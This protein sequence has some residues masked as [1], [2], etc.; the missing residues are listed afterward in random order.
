MLH[1][2]ATRR[3]LL[4]HAGTGHFTSLVTV[5]GVTTRIPLFTIDPDS[6]E[7]APLPLRYFT[8][9]GGNW[10]GF[11]TAWATEPDGLA[12][13]EPFV[14]TVTTELI[15]EQQAHFL[16]LEQYE[17][18]RMELPPLASRLA[19]VYLD[20]LQRRSREAMSPDEQ[21]WN[22]LSELHQVPTDSSR[23]AQIYFLS[24]LFGVYFLC[25]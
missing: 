3:P 6:A 18:T 7:V 15:L 4:L 21:W 5:E 19:E 10:R 17:D 8:R 16:T 13:L 9:G 1:S 24:F 22:G 2:Y 23:P 12:V 25:D 14:G 20:N 11:T